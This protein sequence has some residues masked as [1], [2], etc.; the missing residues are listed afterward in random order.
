MS[1]LH[2]RLLRMLP[3]IMLKILAPA[4]GQADQEYG[5]VH[6]RNHEG[7]FVAGEPVTVAF[8]GALAQ[9]PDSIAIYRVNMCCSPDQLSAVNS[10]HWSYL[11]SGQSGDGL[12]TVTPAEVG[13]YYVILIGGGNGH[14]ERTDPSN[15]M[16]IRVQAGA[17]SVVHVN[18]QGDTPFIQ[19]Q[20][21]TVGFTD[22]QQ[23]TAGNR[24]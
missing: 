17:F 5:T 15:R 2:D 13:D 3:L 22:A 23:C 20:L 6:L 24:L 8:S 14:T 1:F 18:D 11:G 16:Q 12:V 7:A 10:S 21:V 4:S 19:G 9:P